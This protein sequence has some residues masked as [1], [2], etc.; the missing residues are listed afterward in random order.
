MSLNLPE[1]KKYG[2]FHFLFKNFPKDENNF[3]NIFGWFLKKINKLKI[4]Q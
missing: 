1:R 2:E 3:F 4:L